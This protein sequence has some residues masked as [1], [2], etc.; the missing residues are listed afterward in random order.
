M[1]QYD[2]NLREY[3]RIIRNRKAFI[4]IITIV[5]TLFSLG[6]AIVRAPSP[7]YETACSIKFEKSVSPLGLYTKFISWGA[8]SEIETQMAVIKGYLVFKRTASALGLIDEDRD[9]DTRLGEIITNLQSQVTVTRE[10]YSNIVSITARA[11]SPKFAAALA[12]QVALA[13]RD[14]HDEEVNQRT[15][16][17]IKF[18]KGQLEDVGARLRDS[19]ERLKGFREDKNIIALT[20]Q[21]SNLLSRV[22]A[23][24]AER[25]STV[26]AKRELEEVMK[27]IREASSD[28]LSSRGAFSSERAT[29]L[30]QKLNSRLIDLMIKRD[31]LLVECTPSHPEVVAINRQVAEI[32]QKMT[33]ELESHLKAHTKK[34]EELRKEIEIL[35]ERIRGLP[36]RGLELSRLE[37]D[38]D[39]FSQ[40]CSLLET[41]YQEALIQD[42]E[43]P[44]E[45]TIVRPAFEPSRPINPPQTASSAFLGVMIGLVLGVVFA[46]I[47]ETFDTSLGAIEDVEQT[48]GLQVLG[49]IPHIDAKDIRAS[50][51]DQYQQGAGVD[52]VIR[53]ACLIPNFGPQSVLAES[54]RSLRTNIQ[55]SALDK[56]AKTIV[57]TS[58]AP[59][60]GKTS[61]AA[62]LAIAMAQAGLKAL[63]MGT[64]LR[65]PS[66]YRIFG[67]DAV[68]GVTEVLLSNYDLS[69]TVKTV[70]DLMMGKMNMDKIMLTPGIDNLHIMT[71]GTIPLN[72]AEL[73]QSERFKR[74]IDEV[75][76][77]YDV[78]LMDTPPLVS[79]T[80][81]SILAMKADGVLL[82]YR[83]GKVARGVLKRARAQLEQVNANIIGVV[84]NGVK[85]EI[86]VDYDKYYQYY[87]YYG[88]EA[89]KKRRKEKNRQRESHKLFRVFS[90]VIPLS[91]LIVGLL[92][93]N[94]IIHPNK[95]LIGNEPPSGEE[96]IPLS[97]AQVIEP[98]E[99]NAALAVPRISSPPPSIHHPYSLQ[100]GSFK[101]LQQ[102]YKAI[103]LL[104]NRGL[105]PYGNQ[106]DLGEK[107]RWFRVFVGYFETLEEA[108]EFR[109]SVGITAGRIVN[110]AYTN[111]IGYFALKSDMEEKVRSIEEAGYLPYSIGDPQVGY[112]LLAGAYITKEGAA[113]MAR[114]LKEAGIESRVVLR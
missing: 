50:L 100:A 2:I 6:L 70:A 96:N 55:F 84:L 110:T 39:R 90:L 37:R 82:V 47:V 75:R 56:N 31:T 9:N 88:V 104:R 35:R 103:S 108:E 57:L 60:E 114:E 67:L 61:V 63:L 86:S 33:T 49:L 7:L 51:K 107:G 15:G 24:E 28:S 93:Q 38:V 98:G 32:R 95:Y 29:A 99:I 78:V 112:R 77:Q 21:S 14:T 58:A 18:I 36:N 81:A 8:G 11:S 23:M 80:D 97:S 34:G 111:E 4:V 52:T 66:L 3:W 72:P 42:A 71:C 30:Y 68:P 91:F 106:V 76:H 102:F 12:N 46:F 64:D 19:E 94:G 1:A 74:F 16:E 62:N 25:A 85:A 79:A 43:K 109:K 92:W 53:D 54:F 113:Q 69:E 17:A 5:L 59:E 101:S 89:K 10:G 83:A 44:E 22:Q 26:E 87:S 20:S 41:K 45:V 27:R 73:I 65:K 48:L 13:Y 105:L 40:T